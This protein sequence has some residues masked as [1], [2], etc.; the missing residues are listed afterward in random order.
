LPHTCEVRAQ[1]C[2]KHPFQ[3]R[4]SVESAVKTTAVFRFNTTR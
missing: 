3:P 1:P 2:W 4:P